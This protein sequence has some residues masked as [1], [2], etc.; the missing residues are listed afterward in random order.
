MTRISTKAN[1]KLDVEQACRKIWL[2]DISSGFEE[3][4][5]RGADQGDPG[6]EGLGRCGSRALWRGAGTTITARDRHPSA[7]RK[8]RLFLSRWAFR[9]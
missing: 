2:L 8:D 3:I 7:E 1:G 9:R 6:E 5:G 4:A